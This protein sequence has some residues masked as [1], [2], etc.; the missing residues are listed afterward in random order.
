MSWNKVGPGFITHE[1]KQC[2]SMG[3][4]LLFVLAFVGNF[5]ELE[6]KKG[7]MVKYLQKSFF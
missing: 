3:V 4:G 5:P 7:D 2:V 1:A 6:I